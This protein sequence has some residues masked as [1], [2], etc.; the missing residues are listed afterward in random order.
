[1]PVSEWGMYEPTVVELGRG[2]F[3]EPETMKILIVYLYMNNT[4]AESCIVLYHNIYQKTK[5]ITMSA[6]Y[7]IVKPLDDNSIFIL[8]NLLH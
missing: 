7:N 5:D 3:K 1:M 6:F 4:L 2:T 8:L